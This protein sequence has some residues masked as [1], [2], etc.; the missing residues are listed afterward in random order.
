MYVMNVLFLNHKII[1]CGVYQYGKRVFEILQKDSEINYIYKEVS[2][3]HEYKAALE[4]SPH[5]IIYN[6]HEATMRWLHSSTIQKSVPNVGIPHESAEHL[7]DVV[8]NIDP[9]APESENRFSLPR[10]I[11]ENIEEMIVPCESESVHQFIHEYT[12]TN[13]P[14]FGTFGFG[15][16]FKGFDKIVELVNEQYDNAVIKMV[17]PISAFDPNPNTNRNMRNLC[18]QKNK[19]PGVKLMITHDFFS[20][21]DILKFLNS[22]TMNIFLYDKLN[23]RGISSTIDYALSSK[24]P[25]AISD[26]CMFRNIYSDNICVYK[27]SLDEC[28]QASSDHCAVFLQKYSNALFID[29]FRQIMLP[30][31]KKEETVI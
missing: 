25:L 19:K 8:C 15:F 4:H 24:K 13:V 10:P 1:Q 20:T 27:R 16:N 7:F 28:L 26:S 31:R 11:Y 21:A 17:I 12:N 6:Y 22:T 3:V 5:V 9:D 2:N 14:I 23:G 18:I 30:L 29:K